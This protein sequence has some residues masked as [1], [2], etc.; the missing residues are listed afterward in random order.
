MDIILPRREMIRACLTAIGGIAVARFVSACVGYEY[1]TPYGSPLVVTRSES[2][3]AL[4]AFLRDRRGVGYTAKRS[5]PLIVSVGGTQG[6]WE[7]LI[8]DEDPLNEE[9]V[10][11]HRYPVSTGDVVQPYFREFASAKER[12][13]ALRS[14]K[15]DSAEARIMEE[16]G[17]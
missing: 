1:G 3:A 10:G 8:N 2:G 6:N 9:E 13:D 5:G 7:F 14:E 17:G 12:A 16:I 11:T 4:Y 15:M